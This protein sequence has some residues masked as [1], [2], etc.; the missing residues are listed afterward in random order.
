M[1]LNRH[2]KNSFTVFCYSENNISAGVASV[3]DYNTLILGFPFETIQEASA[4]N[5]LMKNILQFIFPD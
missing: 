3:G 2:R 5:A 1:P 4:R